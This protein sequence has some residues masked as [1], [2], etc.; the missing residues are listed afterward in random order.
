MALDL[1]KIIKA[2][3]KLEANKASAIKKRDEMLQQANAE[4]AEMQSQLDELNKTRRVVEKLM[5]QQEAELEKITR[6]VEGFKKKS[7]AEE[8]SGEHEEVVKEAPAEETDFEESEQDYGEGT[9]SKPEPDQGEETMADL[10]EPEQKQ[11]FF[12]HR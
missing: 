3:D 12:F 11:N 6:K 8:E 4:I 5:A 7:K 2:I 10:K 1:K 9:V